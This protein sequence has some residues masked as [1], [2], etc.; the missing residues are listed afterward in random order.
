MAGRHRFTNTMPATG[1]PYEDICNVCKRK[2]SAHFDD[3]FGYTCN[4]CYIKLV[5][6][7]KQRGINPWG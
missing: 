2:P 3:F 1:N 5:M 7:Y 6:R 4:L